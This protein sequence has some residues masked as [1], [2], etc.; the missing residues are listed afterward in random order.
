MSGVAPALTSK[1]AVTGSQAKP[2]RR[3]TRRSRDTERREVRASWQAQSP[4]LAKL[5][6]KR[7]DRI[8]AIP[9]RSARSAALLVDGRRKLWILVGRACCMV[10]ANVCLLYT[11][12]A[13]DDLLC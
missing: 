1:P 11:S 2:A 10:E 6:T 5:P 7:A 9:A 4:Q 13:A 8:E 12:D 3:E